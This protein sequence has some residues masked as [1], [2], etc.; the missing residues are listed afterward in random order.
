[1]LRIFTACLFILLFCVPAHADII[2]K[3]MKPIQVTAWIKNMADYPEYTFVQLETLGGSVRRTVVLKEGDPINQGYKFNKLEILAIPNA[4][5]KATP[6]ESL[7]LMNDPEFARTRGKIDVGQELVD[8][9]SPLKWKDVHYTMNLNGN[10]IELTKVNERG[11]GE[12]AKAMA[13]TGM[14]QAFLL[15]FVV[16]LLVFAVVIRGWFKVTELGNLR[17]FL[18]VLGAQMAT[19]PLLWFIITK[20]SL[21]GFGVTLGAESF[22]ITVE[23]VFYRFVARLNWKQAATVAAACNVISFGFGLIFF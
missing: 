18:T 10:V 14:T 9:T 3:D 6:L 21:V 8:K 12:P 13:W 17:L 11:L 15:T 4:K 5:L 23:A 7:D 2:P 16:E 22:A 1:M 20:Y 19:L